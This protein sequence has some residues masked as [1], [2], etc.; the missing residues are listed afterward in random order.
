M[1]ATNLFFFLLLFLFS[2]SRTLVKRVF[3]NSTYPKPVRA[4]SVYSSDPR[5]I[6]QLV[7]PLLEPRTILHLADVRFDPRR[8]I[9][10]ENY[11]S[12][13]HVPSDSDAHMN[14]LTL[15]DLEASE[16]SQRIWTSFVENNQT[17]IRGT[18]TVRTNML[19]DMVVPVEGILT[20][21]T[22]INL[23]LSD[24]GIAVLNFSATQVRLAKSMMLPVKN[25]ADFP[26]RVRLVPDPWSKNSHVSSLNPFQKL[27]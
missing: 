11:L 7:R 1:H 9:S 4:I 16:Q 18:V 15:M 10:Q 14:S 26:L 22:V 19:P 12:Q 6:V 5:F 21:P 17:V 2:L 24:T 20:R 23:P 8:C 25:D 27:L 13:P 3:L